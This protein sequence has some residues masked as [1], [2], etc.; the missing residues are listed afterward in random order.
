MPKPLFKDLNILRFHELYKSQIASL[1][2][3][4][5]H[6]NLPDDLNP[7]FITRSSAHSRDLRNATNQR[8]YTST[9]RNTKYGSDSISQVGSILLNEMKDLELFNTNNSKNTFMTK[10]KEHLINQY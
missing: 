3:D 2:W 8:L 4:F 10:Y 5:D 6:G 9:R 1:M 7:L